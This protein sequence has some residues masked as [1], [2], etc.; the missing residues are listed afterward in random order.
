MYLLKI[1]QP[2]KKPAVH[3]TAGFCF[4]GLSRQNVVHYGEQLFFVEGL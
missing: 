2:I 3:R 1:D 4:Y